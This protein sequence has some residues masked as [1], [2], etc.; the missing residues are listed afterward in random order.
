MATEWRTAGVSR[1]VRVSTSRLTPAVRHLLKRKTMSKP[2][3]V[4]HVVLA[5]DCGGLERVVL[6]LVREGQRLGQQVAVFCLERPG[7]LA[8]Q[9]EALG[10]LLHCFHKP[11]GLQ[12]S[13]ISQLKNIFRKQRP[14]VVHCHQVG[15]LIY[16]GRAARRAGVPLVVHTEHGNHFQRGDNGV[17]VRSRKAWLWWFAARYAAK[18]FCVTR[19][20]ADDLARRGIV[21]R[22]KLE[23]LAN[24]IDTETFAAPANGEDF[25]R[26]L[27]L[28]CGAPIIGT[29]GR[30]NEIKQQDL[31]VRA[32]AKVR[33]EFPSACLLLVGDG[34]MRGRLQ[35][36]ASALNL[37]DAVR[38]AGYQPHPEALS[39]RYG[40]VRLDEP[41][42]GDAVGHPGGV[43][44]GVAGRCFSRGRC[45]RSGS[46]WL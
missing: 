40:C 11:P 46:A 31:L 24:G 7:D 13:I 28:P 12:L 5:L 29:V 32:F 30:L 19:D 17:P 34:P 8:A 20:I 22:G 26:S 38:F 18:F 44:G 16:A 14:D 42:G 35:E 2:L 4:T 33:V 41:H 37:N 6:D 36:L 25:R 27:G 23:V 3:K 1:L 43:G 21:P 10:A 9:V 15:A 39:P 45:S